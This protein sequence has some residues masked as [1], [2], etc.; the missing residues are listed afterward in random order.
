LENEVVLKTKLTQPLKWHGGK[1]YLAGRI[2]A[3]MPRHLHYVEPYAGGLSVLLE[4][5]PFD[6]TKYWGTKGF[7]QG[8][9]EVVNDVNRELTN[10]W[11]VLQRED[12]FADF[13][14]IVS[15]VPFSEI[16]WEESEARQ[17]PSAERDVDAAVAFFI[18]CR[19]SRAGKFNVFATLSRNRT[20]RMMNEQAAAWMNAVSGLAAVAA[21]LK[22]VVILNMDAIEAIRQEDGPRTLFYLDPPYLHETRV[23]TEDYK[24][25]MTCEQHERLLETIRQCEGKVI[26]SGYPNK[27]YNGALRDWKYVDIEIDN[28]ASAAKEKPI[29]TE[30]LWMNYDP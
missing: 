10:F 7:E 6:Q 22:R 15:A 27:L 1:H 25:E 12:C 5:D 17:T 4:K 13:Q 2:I 29:K 28:K 19:Q 30:R 21:R 8:I 23:T 3:L 26:L 14:R 20:R 24:H 11:R 18:R 16:E 9:S